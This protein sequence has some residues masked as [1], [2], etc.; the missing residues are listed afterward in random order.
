MVPG[1]DTAR[2]VL[3]SDRCGLEDLCLSWDEFDPAASLLVLDSSWMRRWRVSWRR[4]GST[5]ACAVPDLGSVTSAGCEPVRRF[6]WRTGQRH[7]PGLQYLVSTGRHHGFESLAEQ[8]LLLAVDFAAGATEVLG[9]PSRW[10][11]ATRAGWQE[12]IPDFLIR[13]GGRDVVLVDVRPAGRIPTVTAHEVVPGGDISAEIPPDVGIDIG[14]YEV[15]AT[16]ARVGTVTEAVFEQGASYV[17]V[18]TDGLVLS[19]TVMLPAGVVTL[20]GTDQSVHIDCRRQQIHDAPTYLPERR[21][22]PTYL[23]ELADYY[24]SIQT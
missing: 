7:R 16:D 8:R 2:G 20:V 6:A 14:G 4:S 19:T 15:R 1:R 11:F 9:Q 12:H 5:V 22:H 10:R 18:D 13:R 21:N 17:I 23:T 24:Q 3:A